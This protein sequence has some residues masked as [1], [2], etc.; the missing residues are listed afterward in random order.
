MDGKRC[1]YSLLPHN[2]PLHYLMTSNDGYLRCLT[3]STFWAN[4][5]NVVANSQSSLGYIGRVWPGQ[6]SF[7]CS[8]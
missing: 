4:S 1:T 2:V 3:L 8:V 5:I 6:V 7:R